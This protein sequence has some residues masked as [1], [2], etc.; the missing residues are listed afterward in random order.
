MTERH[1]NLE[2]QFATEVNFFL[3]Q[4]YIYNICISTWQN[5]FQ[6]VHFSNTSVCFAWL[7]RTFS[8]RVSQNYSLWLKVW[9]CF[10][11]SIPPKH[12]LDFQARLY[13][14]TWKDHDF[15][16]DC[17]TFSDDNGFIV[18][19]TDLDLLC[20]CRSF[21]NFEDGPICSFPKNCFTRAT[22][23]IE[24]WVMYVFSSMN[25]NQQC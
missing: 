11:R 6:Y 24:S 8:K 16:T 19:G 4:T 20:L 7:F 2:G 5:Q 17:E 25:W 22:W 18:A 9:Q 23:S 14:F 3:G 12:S 13:L 21:Y 10:Y 15:I 1:T